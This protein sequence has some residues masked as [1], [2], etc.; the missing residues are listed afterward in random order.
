MNQQ[1]SLKWQRFNFNYIKCYKR[2]RYTR[3]S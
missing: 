2:K 1:T 3:S